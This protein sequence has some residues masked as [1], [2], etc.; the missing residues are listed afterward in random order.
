MGAYS[1]V[2]DHARA[3]TCARALGDIDSIVEQYLRIG[4]KEELRI[5]LE[6]LIEQAGPAICIASKA[7]LK[8][9][10][11]SCVQWLYLDQMDWNNFSEMEAEVLHQ[12]DE[13]AVLH[14]HQFYVEIDST[15][16]YEWILLNQLLESHDKFVVEAAI[17][18][19]HDWHDLEHVEDLSEDPEDMCR[20]RYGD[21]ID[22]EIFDY[23]DWETMAEDFVSQ[24][25]IQSL[26][27]VTGFVYFWEI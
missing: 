20:E 3:L 14:S 11:A 1:K 18:Q 23:V 17:A 21:D 9:G 13:F 4:D 7:A 8:R 25:T 2:R 24:G 27:T 19:M 16:P 22:W 12:N 10:E 26:K 6:S 5:Y 15:R